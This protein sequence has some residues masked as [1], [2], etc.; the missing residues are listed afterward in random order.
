MKDTVGEIIEH[1]RDITGRNIDREE[2]GPQI[3]E[4]VESLALNPQRAGD[5]ILDLGGEEIT[6]ART[7][8]GLIVCLN[9]RYVEIG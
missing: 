8:G 3:N 2:F 9:V 1:I 5:R 4:I 6:I 7:D